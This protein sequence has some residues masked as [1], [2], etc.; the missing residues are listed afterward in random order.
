[1]LS[2]VNVMMLIGCEYD[3]ND[4]IENDNDRGVD[5]EMIVVV[6][7]GGIENVTRRALRKNQK[8]TVLDAERQWN[9]M[10]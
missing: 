2:N 10:L 5:A 9:S 4:E 1:M 3:R 7:E 6:G 8:N